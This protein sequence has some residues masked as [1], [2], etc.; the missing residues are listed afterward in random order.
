MIEL[1]VVF[2]IRVVDVEIRVVV[3]RHK[4]VEI[5]LKDMVA[6]C[7]RLTHKGHLVTKFMVEVLEE[8]ARN[9]KDNGVEDDDYIVDLNC[10]TMSLP[11]VNDDSMC[12][13]S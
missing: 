2:Q 11:N 9:V 12:L 8:V 3:V 13:P 6:N 7:L 4:V 5:D 10:S 1:V